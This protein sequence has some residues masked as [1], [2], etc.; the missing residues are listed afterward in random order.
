M[1]LEWFDIEDAPISSEHARELARQGRL[2]IASRY[3]DDRV[4]L[5]AKSMRVWSGCSEAWHSD[6][7]PD[8]Q[9]QRPHP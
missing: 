1:K 9:R 5:V 8:A 7:S 3:F 4:E 6:A 2:V